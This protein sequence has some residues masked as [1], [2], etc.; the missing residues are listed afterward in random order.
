M[1]V[2]LSTTP[3]RIVADPSAIVAYLR[4]ETGADVVAHQFVLGGIWMHEVNVAELCFTLPR[5]M[6]DV[7]TPESVLEWLVKAGIET[8]AGFDR[9]WGMRVTAI[10]RAAPAL[11]IGD[12]VAVALAGDMKLPLLTAEHAFEDASGYAKMLFI[13]PRPRKRKP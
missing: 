12:G 13:R 3:S 1:D 6:P 10:R 4:N 7:F 2:P 8:K 9:E 5:K 11:N